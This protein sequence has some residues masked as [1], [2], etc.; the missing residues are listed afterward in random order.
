VVAVRHIQQI[1][2]WLVLVVMAVAV[3][4]RQELPL[5]LLELRELQ[6]LVAVVVAHNKQ[7][8]QVVALAL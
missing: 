7:Q 5:E 2:M 3:L 6:T 1:V 8:A 4:V